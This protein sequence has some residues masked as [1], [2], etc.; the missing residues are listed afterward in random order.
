[1]NSQ[2]PRLI[3]LACCIL[4]TAA[5]VNS[6]PASAQVGE[7]TYHQPIVLPSINL[8]HLKISNLPDLLFT[9]IG[10]LLCANPVA[11]ENAL[12][13]TPP[14]DWSIREPGDASILGFATEQSVN[15]GDT[16]I[17]TSS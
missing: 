12:A 7:L 15:V 16:V 10:R 2:R 4:V 11:C 17:F 3:S 1:M 13:G 9:I 14:S 6:V 8:N 5:L